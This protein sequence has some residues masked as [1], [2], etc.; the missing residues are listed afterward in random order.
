MF[1]SSFLNRKSC[2]IVMLKPYLLLLVVIGFFLYVPSLFGGFMW[3]DEDFVYENQFVKNFRIDKFVTSDAIA[4]R[5]KVSNYYR[6]VQL[7][8]YS[9][10]HALFGFSPF[11]FHL[12]N[13][14]VHTG[15]A[16]AV[17]LFFALFSGQLLISFLI[18]L[19]FLM[20]PV[21]TEAV[22]YISGL[23]DPLVALFGFTS[24]IFFL[25][26]EKRPSFYWLSIFFFILT[27][28]SKETGVVFTGLITLLWLLFDKKK[29]LTVLFPFFL[30]TGIYLL[31]HITVINRQDMTLV[32][33]NSV[34]A[35]SI[36]ARLLTFIQNLFTYGG[37]LIFPKD[38]FMERDFTV[39]LQTNPLNPSLILFV[40]INGIILGALWK[41]R[42][43]IQRFRLLLFS[44]LGFFITF[45]PFSGIMLINGI[46]YE[47][48]LYLPLIFF[49]SGMLFA[50]PRLSPK[51]IIAIAG[52]ILVLF[53]G[54]TI[55]RQME[56]IDAIKFYRQT[57]E[58][59]PQSI[60]VRN[61]L[62]MA[63]ATSGD[64]NAAI[65]EY[66]EA[67]KLNNRI[68]NLYHNLGNAYLTK[69]DA[70][71]AE[72]QFQKAIEVDPGFIFSYRALLELYQQTGQRDKF[73]KL[74]EE[75]QNRFAKP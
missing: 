11:P 37:L 66:T 20:H 26:R 43:Q 23:S 1:Y 59:A 4:G 52:C 8:I 62:G 35:T 18:A 58:H 75:Y 34:Y 12:M 25:K 36:V 9:T 48:F 63:Y 72:Q 44:Y 15:A 14:I 56:W 61:N 19:F 33:G 5:G 60:R 51:I 31:F 53:A 64:I 10:T 70:A 69:G 46:F 32:W 27:L 42:H 55:L 40:I 38:L 17:F 67:L 41:I 16:T 30:M 49:F 28:L 3:D 47:H 73:T 68:P 21:Q 22:S 2:F 50:L 24:L 7:T 74:L 29:K 65:G 13:V 71:T 45:A 57:L 6:P 39:S 54:R